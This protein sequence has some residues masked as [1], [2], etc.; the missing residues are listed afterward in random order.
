[1]SNSENKF[2]WEKEHH[3]RDVT[4]RK[5][6]PDSWPYTR[7]NPFPADM[8]DPAFPKGQQLQMTMCKMHE[9]FVTQV[10]LVPLMEK[11]HWEELS[12]K[13]IDI[14]SD[15]GL[16]ALHFR[17]VHEFQKAIDKTAHDDGFTTGFDS[18]Y[19]DSY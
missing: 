11:D 14:L 16:N 13:D 15:Y 12:D 19:D 18:D 17:L 6:H 10:C 8:N 4:Q 1:M 3:D 5:H 7:E 9:L 2:N